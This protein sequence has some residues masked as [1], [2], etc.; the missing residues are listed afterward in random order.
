[1]FCS[2]CK[3][4]LEV[5]FLMIARAMGC[6]FVFVFLIMSTPFSKFLYARQLRFPDDA[7]PAVEKVI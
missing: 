4:M 5:L 1:M 3:P 6:C 7:S 2:C